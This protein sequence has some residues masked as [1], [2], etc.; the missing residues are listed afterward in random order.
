MVSQERGAGV[1]SMQVEEDNV[2]GKAV[3]GKRHLGFV[4]T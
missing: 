1:N 3:P 4:L 2:V